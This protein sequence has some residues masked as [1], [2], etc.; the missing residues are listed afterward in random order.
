MTK[1]VSIDLAKKHMRAMGIRFEEGRTKAAAKL[2]HIDEKS[3]SWKV[4]TEG[5]Q[6][7]IVKKHEK[8]RKK[9]YALSGEEEYPVHSRDLEA[10]RVTRGTTVSGKDFEVEDNWKR[11]GRSERSIGEEWTGYTV[12]KVKSSARARLKADLNKEG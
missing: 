9:L 4:E 12:F 3:D 7:N 10:T 5:N 11:T 8:P 2:H 1:N 6:I